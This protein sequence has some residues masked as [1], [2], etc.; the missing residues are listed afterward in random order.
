ME[1]YLDFAK[2]IAMQAG[3]IMLKYFKED[4]G[5][6]YKFDQTIVTKA[7]TEIN[8]YLIKQVKEKDR[9]GVWLGRHICYK[10]TQVSKDKLNEDRNLM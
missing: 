3:Q 4:N 8:Q 9:W 1:E 7:D 5:A 10:I 2:Q 6:N